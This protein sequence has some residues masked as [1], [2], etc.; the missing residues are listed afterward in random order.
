MEFNN[1]FIDAMCVIAG[2]Q[3]PFYMEDEYQIYKSFLLYKE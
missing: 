1:A 3:F 2:T